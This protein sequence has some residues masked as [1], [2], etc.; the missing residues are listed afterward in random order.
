[1]DKGTHFYHC[2]FQAHPP[3]DLRWSG[4]HWDVGVHSARRSNHLMTA[5]ST[6]VDPAQETKIWLRPTLRV[7]VVVPRIRGGPPGRHDDRRRLR[8]F[9]R[10]SA[11]L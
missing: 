9:Q 10:R 1:M 3:R 7:V 11:G 2:D 4:T 8:Q 5:L 6:I